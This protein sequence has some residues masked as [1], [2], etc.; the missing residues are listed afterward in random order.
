MFHVRIDFRWKM[1]KIKDFFF[2]GICFWSAFI[3]FLICIYRSPLLNIYIECSPLKERFYYIFSPKAQAEKT[4]S[5]EEMAEKEPVRAASSTRTKTRHTS[6]KDNQV[7]STKEIAS[8][9][10]TS[11]TKQPVRSTRTKTRAQHTQPTVEEK[12]KK[13]SGKADFLF[14]L[15]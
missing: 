7:E 8:D 1:K 15:L 5:D 9:D 11:P 6:K 2:A 4:D 3:L 10:L 12:N 14:T 13:D